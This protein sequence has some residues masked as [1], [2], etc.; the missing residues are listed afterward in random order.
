MLLYVF[1]FE[2]DSFPGAGTP[3]HDEWHSAMVRTDRPQGDSGYC[4]QRHS[5]RGI[6]ANVTT[7]LLLRVLLI[8]YAEEGQGTLDDPA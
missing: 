3:A 5:D 7:M 4:L 1:A 6:G 8:E 2:Y